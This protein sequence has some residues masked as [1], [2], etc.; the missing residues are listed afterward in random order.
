MDIRQFLYLDRRKKRMVDFYEYYDMKHVYKDFIL[1][2]KKKTM[3]L[4]IKNK[5]DYFYQKE[6]IIEKK[7]KAY[8]LGEY[9]PFEHLINVS[10]IEK[11]KN[12]L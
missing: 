3:K 11:H 5:N 2:A 6:K 12:I 7:R 4:M 1:N 10:E 8:D 9:I